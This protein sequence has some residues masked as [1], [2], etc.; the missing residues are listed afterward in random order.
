MA[1]RQYVGARYVPKFFSGE[2]GSTEWVSGVQYE[3]LTIVTHLGNSYT[4]KKPVPVGIDITNTEYWASTGMWN[5]Q[6]EQYREEVEQ[7]SEEVEQLDE[8]VE[9][10]TNLL[11]FKNKKILILGDSI[12]NETVNAPNWVTH[13]KNKLDGI[14]TAIDNNSVIGRKMGDLPTVLSS[15]DSLDYDLIIVFLGTNDFGDNNDMGT[16]Y[17]DVDTTKFASA[18]GNSVVA[19]KNKSTATR[20]PIVYAITPLPRT[21]HSYNSYLTLR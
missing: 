20:K 4:S 3:A 15:Y 13:F 16:S 11:Y 17:N 2:G 6:V 19:I 7:L 9:N 10:F 21:D 14:A 1:T 12:S 5:S 8:D 18:W